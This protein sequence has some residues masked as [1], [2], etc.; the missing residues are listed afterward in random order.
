MEPQDVVFVRTCSYCGEPLG[1]SGSDIVDF[2]FVAATGYARPTLFGKA[3]ARCVR[4][5]LPRRIER[6]FEQV[7]VEE[8]RQKPPL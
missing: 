4:G 6:E 2:S 5:F 1:R 8:L 7:F 3:H